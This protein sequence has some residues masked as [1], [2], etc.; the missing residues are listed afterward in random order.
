[1]NQNK[2][3]SNKKKSLSEI[4]AEK[5]QYIKQ[6]KLEMDMLVTRYDEDS[7]TKFQLIAWS[8]VALVLGVIVGIFI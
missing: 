8:V 2:N 1:M 6:L 3:K 4:V 7:I 5:E